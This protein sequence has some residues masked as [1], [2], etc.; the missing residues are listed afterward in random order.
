MNSS[1]LSV[2]HIND[3]MAKYMTLPDNWHSKNYR[4]EFAEIINSL[5]KKEVM[6]E[7]ANTNVHTLTI[8]ETTDISTN[9]CPIL[10][11]KF[12][13]NNFD[14]YNVVFGGIIQLKACDSTAIV[15]EIKKFYTKHQLN[16][17]KIVMFT[18]DG[19]L[20][21]LSR[22]NGV[23]AQLKKEISYL[24]QQHCV[25]HREDLG[26]TD[27]WKGIKLLSEVETLMCTIYTMFSH[28]SNKKQ[29]LKRNCCSLRT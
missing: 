14:V 5:I 21:M 13:P 28:S 2:Q 17:Q 11:F 9:K 20:V 8:D 6:S 3:H 24:T 25:A 19:G 12:Q 16:L 22:Y 26:I 4:F 29:K 10:Y 27:M 18:S 15:H 23:A 7:L 1:I